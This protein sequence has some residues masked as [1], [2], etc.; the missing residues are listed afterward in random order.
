MY[1]EKL[2]Y[3]SHISYKHN[4]QK[5]ISEIHQEHV[6]SLALFKIYISTVSRQKLPKKKKVKTTKLNPNWSRSKGWIGVANMFNPS[7]KFFVCKRHESSSILHIFIA[8]QHFNERLAG[9]L[10]N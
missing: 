1:S 10:W 2:Q 9:E 4:Y 5:C 6:T 3:F 7:V 8:F